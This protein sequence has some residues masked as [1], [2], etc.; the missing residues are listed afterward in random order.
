MYRGV[1]LPVE[2]DLS[3]WMEIEPGGT[4]YL[5]LSRRSLHIDGQEGA[6]DDTATATL[7]RLVDIL[8][9]D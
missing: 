7:L 3:R 4:Y 8:K 6:V 9:E 2:G 5:A 1:A